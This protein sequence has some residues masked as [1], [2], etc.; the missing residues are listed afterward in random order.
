MKKYKSEETAESAGVECV[1][2]CEWCEHYCDERDSECVTD[3]PGGDPMMMCDDCYSGV[4]KCECG[5]WY[6]DDT[7][8][9]DGGCHAGHNAHLWPYRCERCCEADKEAKREE[10]E[11]DERIYSCPADVYRMAEEIVDSPAWDGTAETA[12]DLVTSACDAEIRDLYSEMDLAEDELDEAVAAGD[13]TPLP[14]GNYERA[15]DGAII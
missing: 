1:V 6:H 15:R 12:D 9:I 5:A 7:G 3:R 4:N 14:N 2:Y 8:I 11:R 13:L 10:D